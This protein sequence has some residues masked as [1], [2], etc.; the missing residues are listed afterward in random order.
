VQVLVPPKVL[1]AAAALKTQLEELFGK[2]DPGEYSARQYADAVWH[3]SEFVQ[4]VRGSDIALFELWQFV[5][6]LRD[7][8][9]GCAHP[10][11]TP[12]SVNHR[13]PD[14][15]AIMQARKVVALAFHLLR[16]AKLSRA[17]A[18][19]LIKRHRQLRPLLGA[20]SHDLGKAA[21]SWYD[22]MKE[23]DTFREAVE[24]ID[25]EFAASGITR[26]EIVALAEQTLR[27]PVLVPRTKP[28]S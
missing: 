17:A 7:L 19:G 18:S 15:S 2:R 22:Q 1:T 4:N 21:E 11:L 6:A 26:D 25:Q 9:R 24:S 13:P 12:K 27:S 23:T 3:L 5:L 16:R 10:R 8:E 28:Q 14:P 20:K